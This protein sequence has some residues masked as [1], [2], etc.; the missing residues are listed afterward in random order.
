[1]LF[2]KCFQS[3]ILHPD[4]NQVSALPRVTKSH[5]PDYRAG[6]SIVPTQK[7]ED[8]RRESYKL[9][10]LK[11]ICAQPKA[12]DTEQMPV[13]RIMIHKLLSHSVVLTVTAISFFLSI[14]H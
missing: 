14:L 6:A 13:E 4:R 3:R 2:W 5:S 1:M 11:E 12:H 9:V 8:E 7:S 10:D